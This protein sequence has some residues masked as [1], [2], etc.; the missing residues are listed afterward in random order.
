MARLQPVGYDRPIPVAPGMTVEF[1]DAGHLLGSAYA[2]MHLESSG[3]TV[4][5][6]GDLG[7]YDRPILPDPTPIEAADVVLMEST[8]GDRVHDPDDGGDKIAAVVNETIAR[9]GKVVI[10]A[11]ALGRVEELLYW[12][13]RLEEERKIPEL[14]VFV[15]SP[16]AASVLALYQKRLHELDPEVAEEAANGHRRAERRMCGF[17]T[18]KLKVVTSIQDSRAVQES[19]APSIVIS[20]SGMAT[21]GRV[22][23]H[24]ARILP[25]AR[26]TVL[27]AGFQAPGT[28]GRLM[29]DGAKFTRIHGRE[30]PVAAHVAALESLSAHADSNEMLR[31]LGG[32]KQPPSALCLVHGE[33]GPMDTLKARIER[34]LHWKVLTPAAGE[35]FSW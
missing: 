6:G 27:F 34:E 3:K 28:R 4:L 14:P 9:G 32:F 22:L 10:P 1:L 19:T 35:S 12:I 15:D 21:G 5:F 18:A 2:R 31:W 16:M 24:L 25:D 30:V 8:Y 7:R 33:P 11:F 20:A 17:C 29:K 13:D 23:H 26:H